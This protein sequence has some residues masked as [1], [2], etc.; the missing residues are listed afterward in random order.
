MR[1]LKARLQ[2]EAVTLREVFGIRIE[3]DTVSYRQHK[4]VYVEDPS[5]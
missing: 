1:R 3:N 5:K 4:A 2:E